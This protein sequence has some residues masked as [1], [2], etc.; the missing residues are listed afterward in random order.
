MITLTEEQYQL[1][2]QY[3]ELVRTVNEAFTYVVTS[4]DDLSY[5]EGDTVLSDIFTAL[6]QLS[7][8]NSQLTILFKDLDAVN[9]SIMQ[10]S[11]V[12]EGVDKLDSVWGNVEA[13]QQFI[14][15]TL[16]PAY[17]SWSEHVLHVLQPYAVA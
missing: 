16:A 3:T 11:Q 9:E 5:T 13:R 1:I 2:Q 14:R 6:Q 15:E 4:F 10:F 17:T 7:G 12:V 8:A